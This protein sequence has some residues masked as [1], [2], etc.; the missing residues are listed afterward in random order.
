MTITRNRIGIGLNGNAIPNAF[1]VWLKGNGAQLGPDNIIAFNTNAGV[2]VQGDGADNNTITRN[3]IYS[4]GGWG[5]DIFPR[6]PNPFNV[7]TTGPNQ[8]IDFPVLTGATP[9]QVTGTACAGCVVEVF[10]ADTN[11]ATYGEGQTFIGAATANGSGNF[12]V[13]VSGVSSGQWVTATA[14]DA[15]G[16]TSEFCLNRVVN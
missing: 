7:P 12:T 9:T 4:N 8:G 15:A 10:I 14:T 6:G 3:S 16:N 13:S 2:K 1:G 11:S 5:I